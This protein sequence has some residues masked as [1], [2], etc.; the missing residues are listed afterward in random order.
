ML[1]SFK[2]GEYFCTVNLSF[3]TLLLGFCRV[4][5]RL[6]WTLL[7]KAHPLEPFLTLI[8]YLQSI[9]ISLGVHYLLLNHLLNSRS[10]G[11]ASLDRFL[12]CPLEN[13]VCT[14]FYT[15]LQFCGR[16]SVINFGPSCI[17]LYSIRV[18]RCILL[19]LGKLW[20]ILSD[21]GYFEFNF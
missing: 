4:I 3:R 10:V 9:L 21:L 5:F 1:G 18:V 20:S 19:I 14:V 17:F 11:L 16:V 15:H 6:L 8:H 12:V 7:Q 2:F 13:W